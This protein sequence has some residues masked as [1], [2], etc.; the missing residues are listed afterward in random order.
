MRLALADHLGVRLKYAEQLSFGFG[1]A[2]QHD[3]V[4]TFPVTP[5]GDVWPSPVIKR[6]TM[7]PLAAGFVGEL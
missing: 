1:I 2:A 4:V 3:T 5:G 7:L 6:T